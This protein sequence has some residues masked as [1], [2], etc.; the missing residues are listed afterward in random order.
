MPA[1]HRPGDLRR[2]DRPFPGLD[3]AAPHPLRDPPDQQHRRRHQLPAARGGP[4]DARIRPRPAAGAPDRRAG[5]EGN[6]DLHDAGRVG[7]EDRSRDAPHPG[8]GR[9]GGGR[10]RDGRGKQRGR[11]RDDARRLRERPLFACLDPQDGEAAGVVQRS[12][13]PLRAGSRPGGNRLRRGPRGIAPF[14]VHSPFRREGSDRRRRR[15][16]EAANGA[17]PSGTRDPDHGEGVRTRSVPGD[18]RAPRVPG[19]R[20]HRDGNVERHGPH[21]PVRHR[22]GDRPCGGGR[23]AVRVRLHP[24]DVSRIE[25]AGIF[26]GRPVRRRPG[27]VPSTSCADAG[28]HRP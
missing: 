1:V 9:S 7:A 22:A 5:P 21:A 14:P 8:R 16:R 2:D 27:D 13:V 19:R 20:R 3:A 10:R 6:A 12:L 15:E 18:L 28:F 24:R 23:P 4:A 17:V 25:G 26:R 11:R